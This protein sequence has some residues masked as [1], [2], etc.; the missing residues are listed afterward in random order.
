[1]N[2]RII[3]K[4][5]MFY[6]E[7]SKLKTSDKK[8]NDTVSDLQYPEGSAINWSI[9]ESLNRSF[10]WWKGFE[11]GDDEKPVSM[12]VEQWNLQKRP[13]YFVNSNDKMHKPSFWSDYIKKNV[14]VNNFMD[15]K[16]EREGMR[17]Y[18][19]YLLRDAYDYCNVNKDR[20]PN[21]EGMFV[22]VEEA[23]LFIDSD[24]TNLKRGSNFYL[25]ELLCRGFKFE[26]FIVVN[27]QSIADINSD[28]REHL[29]SGQHPVIVGNLNRR[30]R[31]YLNDIFPGV[32]QLELREKV[33]NL[34]WG[35]SEWAV[36]YND[37]EFDTF[38]PYPSLSKF[39]ERGK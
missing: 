19:G 1:M 14:V 31:M 15:A 29:T 24:D 38:V 9:K 17:I 3:D 4:V 13:P 21:F 8:D 10:S 5:K 36:Y 39:H 25:T 32:N 22:C 28:I 11:P 16:E 7:F 18:G 6:E 33:N 37:R 27:F 26:I 23:N 34:D 35:G 30:D 12:P 20:N 2:R